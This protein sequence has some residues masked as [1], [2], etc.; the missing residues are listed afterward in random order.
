MGW[1]SYHGHGD[2]PVEWVCCYCAV[3][4]DADCAGRA[5]H[6]SLTEYTRKLGQGGMGGSLVDGVHDLS[7][8][9]LLPIP[10]L[11]TCLPKAQVLSWWEETER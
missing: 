9:G 10:Q 4:G 2:V 7:N 3:L 5:P 6:L 11:L 1:P 8:A